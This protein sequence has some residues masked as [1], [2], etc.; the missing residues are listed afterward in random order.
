MI[1]AKA[2]EKLRRRLG[3]EA[4]VEVEGGGEEVRSVTVRATAAPHLEH[5]LRWAQEARVEAYLDLI[6]GEVARDMDGLFLDAR[7]LDRVVAIDPTS[8]V[9]TVE[10]GV[11]V[12]A[13]EKA[14]G[15]Q[16]FTLGPVPPS[17]RER[18]LL[19]WLLDRDAGWGSGT[20]AIGNGAIGLA[21]LFPSGEAF[22]ARKTPR[23]ATGPSLAKFL[24]GAE[25]FFAIPTSV[26]LGV[27]RKPESRRLGAYRVPDAGAGLALM[28][29]I[30]SKG[31]KAAHLNLLDGAAS[32]AFLKKD[33]C[34]LIVG[35]EGSPTV[36][37]VAEEV[38]RDLIL[39]RRGADLGSALAEEWIAGEAEAVRAAL[40]ERYTAALSWS[41]AEDFHRRVRRALGADA[42]ALRTVFGQAAV[43]GLQAVA[44][45]AEGART[46]KTRAEVLRVAEEAGA[47]LLHEV[48]AGHSIPVDRAAEYGEALGWLAEIG[49][50]LDPAGI[51]QGAVW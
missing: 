32:R 38:A 2:I 35:F 1:P 33:D 51:Y 10:A 12:G 16:G 20:T 19:F 31:L 18:P 37:P 34:V 5:A 30:V 43:D 4:R 47:P 25:G 27:R 48:R 11:R 23:S 7:G 40:D 50:R 17:V 13:L 41:N 6:E 46:D 42:D 24:L 21:G 3:R 29:E 8:L 22:D 15:E 49:E 39:A 14:L 36:A 9:V 44:A 26:T 28:R 45:V